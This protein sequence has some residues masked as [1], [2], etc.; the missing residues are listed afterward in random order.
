MMAKAWVI[1]QFSDT[2]LR[3]DSRKTAAFELFDVPAT[4]ISLSWRERVFFVC[5]ACL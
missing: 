2:E 4:G 1:V 3:V 5:I